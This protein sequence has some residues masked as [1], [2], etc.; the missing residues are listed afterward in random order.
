MR[1]LQVRGGHIFDADIDVRWNKI[2]RYGDN[3][4]SPVDRIDMT[5]ARGE[6]NGE[7]AGAAPDVEHLLQVDGQRA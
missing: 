5:C 7:R 4:R 2:T 1:G 3:A 6:T